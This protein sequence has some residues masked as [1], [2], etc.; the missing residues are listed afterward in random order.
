MSIHGHINQA[1]LP[2]WQYG[3]F[4]S[5]AKVIFIS[6]Y[7]KLKDNMCTVTLMCILSPAVPLG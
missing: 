5:I 6:T 7:F 2:K 3:I 1:V 4:H